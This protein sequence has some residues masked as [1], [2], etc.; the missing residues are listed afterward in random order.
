M[1]SNY[2]LPMNLGNPAELTVLEFAKVIIHATQSRS[3]IAFKL[4]PQDDPKQRQPDITKAKKILG[5][6]P[7]VPLDKGLTDT[8]AYFRTKV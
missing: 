1:M 2:D 4:L 3:K 5:W 7:K 8:I 6:S